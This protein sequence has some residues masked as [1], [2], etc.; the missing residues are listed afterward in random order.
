VQRNP[1]IIGL[2]LVNK[3]T[4]PN[5][6]FFF[7]FSFSPHGPAHFSS[8]FTS[9]LCWTRAVPFFLSFFCTRFFFLASSFFFHL[10][11]LLHSREGVRNLEGA[12]GWKGTRRLRHTAGHGVD[13][14]DHGWALSRACVDDV[15]GE[16][17]QQI[18]ALM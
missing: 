2:G 14:I 7:S 5:L 3:S 1:K 17:T 16:E 13:S 6:L 11:S 10:F 4:G 15:V 9:F 8:F 18:E 12:G